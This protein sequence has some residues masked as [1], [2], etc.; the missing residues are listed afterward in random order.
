[1]YKSGGIGQYPQRTGKK[2]KNKRL[3]MATNI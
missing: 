3:E 2:N 1:M